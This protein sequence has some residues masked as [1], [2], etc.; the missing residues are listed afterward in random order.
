MGGPKIDINWFFLL[1]FFGFSLL[2]YIRKLTALAATHAFGDAVLVFTVIVIIVYGSKN[3]VLEGNHIDT[4]PFVSKTWTDG[5]GL[6]VYAFEGIGLILPVYDVTE[7]KKFYPKLVCIVIATCASIYIGFSL[8]CVFAWGDE[9][10][11]PLVTD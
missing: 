7:D 6:A 9:I 3:L 2:A 8:F 10:D 5:I 1:C 11:S 4:E